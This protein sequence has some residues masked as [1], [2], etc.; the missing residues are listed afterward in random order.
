MIGINMELAGHAGY[1]PE[2]YKITPRSARKTMAQSG[3]NSNIPGA[4]VANAMG[5]KNVASQNSYQRLKHDSHR[6]AITAINRT[7]YGKPDNKFPDIMENE[8]KVVDI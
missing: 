6:A 3:A 1:D 2:V 5:Q 8:K 7:I 4:F